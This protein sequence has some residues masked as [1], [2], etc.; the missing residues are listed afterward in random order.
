MASA[1]ERGHTGVS[2][3]WCVTAFAL[4]VV[5]LSRRWRALRLAG[6]ALF[7]ATLAKIFLY[8]LSSLSSMTR[9]LSFLAS[10]RC[11]CS[12]P[13]STS[14]S[15]S[16]STARTPPEGWPWEASNLRSRWPG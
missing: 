12:P 4:L 14:A 2:A 8:D 10:G 5:G 15:P 16:A 13:S 11:F 7:A 6:L 3:L 9:A 1:F